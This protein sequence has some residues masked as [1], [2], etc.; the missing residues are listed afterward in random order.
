MIDDDPWAGLRRW[1]RREYLRQHEKQRRTGL[2][3]ARRI[4]VTLRGSAQHDVS[5]K[6]NMAQERSM[7]A[8]NLAVV[9]VRPTPWLVAGHL[10]SADLRAV[11]DWVRLN[12]AALIDYWDF[13]IDTDEFLGRL[14]KLP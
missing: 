3:A 11:I 13:L 9:G 6:V 14:Q 2:K 1:H 8:S 12:G 10:S 7:D 5:I 4:G